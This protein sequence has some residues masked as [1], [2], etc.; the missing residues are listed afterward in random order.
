M[1]NIKK[2]IVTDEALHPIAVQIDY[3]DWLELERELHLTEGATLSEILQHCGTIH[4]T[5]DPLEYQK[6]IRGEWM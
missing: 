3:S 2:N 1:K 6:N 5:V 4:L